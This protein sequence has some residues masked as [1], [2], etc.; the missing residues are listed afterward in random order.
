MAKIKSIVTEADVTFMGDVDVEFVSLVGHAANRQPFKVIKGEV[1][2]EHDMSKKAIYSVLVSKDTTEE[3]LQEIV[4][5]HGLSTEEK[6]EIEGYDVYKQIS[7]EEIDFDSR[8]MTALDEGAYA[9]VADLKEESE[10]EGLEKEEFEWETMDKVA[11]SLFSMMDI[12]L[13]TLRQPE[14]DG[15]S[16]KE[17]I[18]SAISNFTNYVTAVLDTAK[19]EDVLENIEVKSE[20]IKEA[21]APKEETPPE[22]KVDVP[23]LIDAAKEELKTDYEAQIKAITDQFEEMKSTLNANLNEHLEAYIKKEDADK[24][25]NAVK[26]ELEDLKNTTKSRNSEVD[27]VTPPSETKT[28]T[29]K[30]HQFTTFV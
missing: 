6:L 4:E 25:I 29:T 2:G 24:E 13:G 5:A 12:V 10:K 30:K 11:D 22:E 9:I 15:Q 19:A 14:A 18:Q 26:E 27:E 17:M 28:K 20:I 16:R 3:K 1:K 8:K 23:A 21:M 7:D